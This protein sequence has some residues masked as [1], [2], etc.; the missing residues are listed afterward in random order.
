MNN[1]QE[2]IYKAA[3]LIIE[4][5]KLLV[6]RSKGKTIFIAPGGKLKP[7]ET[8]KQ[9]LVRELMEELGITV[10]E[11][12]LEEFGSFDAPA[13]GQEEKIVHMATFLVNAF[14]GAL[15]PRSEV[16]KKAWVNSANERKLPLG[17]IFEH[18]VIPR[19]AHQG[20]ID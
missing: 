6:T 19:L 16:E 12:D 2:T 18:M 1:G 8:Y 4:D 17:S 10:S 9:A 7:G 3:G 5:R 20:L 14:Q 15:V 11:D 13:A